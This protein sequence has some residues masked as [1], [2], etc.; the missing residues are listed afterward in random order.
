MLLLH[1]YGGSVKIN[2]SVKCDNILTDYCKLYHQTKFGRLIRFC[3]AGWAAYLAR[4][5]LE[6]TLIGNLMDL[7]GSAL[8]SASKISIRRFVIT[9]KAP[10]RAF[11]W[12]KAATT[13]Y[14]FHI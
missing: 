8:T 12:L 1:L 13:N 5:E 6:I 14:H 7:S 10:T 9:E 4:L 11:S 2:W 3:V